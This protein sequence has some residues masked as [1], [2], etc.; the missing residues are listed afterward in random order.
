MTMTIAR[1]IAGG[2]K[3]D[4]MD[5]VK[6]ILDKLMSGRFI[7]TVIC[8]IVFAYSAITNKLEPAVITAILMMVF[9]QYFKRE[10]RYNGDNR[11]NQDKPK[12]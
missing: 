1:S 10:D 3:G 9:Q 11:S 5:I 4:Y 6:R 8:G 2:H 7:L 12:T